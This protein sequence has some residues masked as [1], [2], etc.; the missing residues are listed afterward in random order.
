MDQLVDKLKKDIENSDDEDEAPSQNIQTL[1]KIARANESH[2]HSSL[3][4][5]VPAQAISQEEVLKAN[6]ASAQ[7]PLTRCPDYEEFS[8]SSSAPRSKPISYNPPLSDK[9]LYLKANYPNGSSPPL[10]GNSLGISYLMAEGQKIYDMVMT[11]AQEA[12]KAQKAKNDSPIT[13]I[14]CDPNIQ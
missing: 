13:T 8:A 10:P 6:L 9:D 12:T 7:K 5:G 3:F 4:P 11:Q 2:T 14:F 1:P